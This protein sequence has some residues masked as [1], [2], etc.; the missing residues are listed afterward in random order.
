MSARGFRAGK[1]SG[2]NAGSHFVKPAIV[3]A[4]NHYK[5]VQEETFAP[6]LYVIR[7]K[8]ID[9]AIAKHNAVPQGLSSSIFTLN[10]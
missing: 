6:I 9:D 4:E 10:M 2:D 3:R 7:V 1:L 8:D 5:T